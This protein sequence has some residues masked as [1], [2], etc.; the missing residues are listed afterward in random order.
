MNN[1]INSPENILNVTLSGLESGL[2]IRHIASFSLSHCGPE[3]QV[4]HVLQQPELLPFDHIP[5]MEAHRCLGVLT[6][7]CDGTPEPVREHMTKLHEG[8]LVAADMP[9]L[10]FLSCLADES[11]RLVVDGIQIQGIVTRS[12]SPEVASTGVR[13]CIDYTP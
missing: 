1:P 12:G 2:H 5:V 4:A 13:I 9:I 3:Q 10:P 7:S 6:R 8:M 11:Y